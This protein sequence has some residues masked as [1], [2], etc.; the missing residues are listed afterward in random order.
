MKNLN[1]GLQM[2]SD[3]E[4]PICTG[5]ERLKIN[6]KKA[7]STQKPEALLY[8][9]IISSSN[10]GDLILDPFFG[11]GTTGVVAKKLNRHWIGIEQNSNYVDLA[12][13][14]LDA[15]E[16]KDFDPTIFD[17]S[18]KKRNQRRVPFGN[19]IEAGF[20]TPGQILYYKDD[21]SI[22]ATIRADSILLLNEFTGSIHQ[23]A[24]Y[25]SGDKPSN[26]W[27]QWLYEDQ[28]GILHP[29]DDLRS[30]YIIKFQNE[31][32]KSP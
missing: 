11:T 9:V 4:I 6:G 1:D 10:P 8:R 16:K 32:G 29:I 20:L 31:E 3:W 28:S 14:R 18:D 5:T 2:R 17:V 24:K 7:H 15:V 27:Q 25:I 30:A 12:Q 23:A 19:L 22:K 13:K 21:K 26:G